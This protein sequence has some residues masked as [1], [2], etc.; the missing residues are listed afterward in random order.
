MNT[1]DM[2]SSIKGTIHT[3][4]YK[5]RARPSME[6]TCQVI[7]PNPLHVVNRQH[8]ELPSSVAVWSPGTDC[9]WLSLGMRE[10]CRELGEMP[11]GEEGGRERGIEREGER[12]GEEGNYRG[13]G[14]LASPQKT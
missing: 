1:I 2:T 14:A 12:R 7:W 13:W 6:V 5:A 10:D 3:S 4:V 8:V 9:R 11:K